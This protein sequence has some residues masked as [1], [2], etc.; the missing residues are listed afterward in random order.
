MVT[1][2]ESTMIAGGLR[3]WSPIADDHGPP[4]IHT[5][6]EDSSNHC[7]IRPMAMTMSIEFTIKK[8]GAKKFIYLSLKARYFHCEKKIR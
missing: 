7:I 4:H 6:R 5:A 3:V 8:K 2:I 1:L